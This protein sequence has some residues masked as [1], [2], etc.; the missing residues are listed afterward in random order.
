MKHIV[1]FLAGAALIA[2]GQAQAGDSVAVAVTGAV[3]PKC[4]ASAFVRQTADN[5]S[6]AIG[7]GYDV[8]NETTGQT[9]ASSRVNLASATP[10]RIADVTAR[11]N[12]GSATLTIATDN[13]FRLRN[14]AGGTGSEIP[15]ALN[16]QGQGGASGI[17][18]SYTAVLTG[19]G[20]GQAQVRP[21]FFVLP[22][23]INP[24]DLVPGTF[25]DTL[26]VTITPNS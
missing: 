21:L 9:F 17:A 16:L 18:A 12:T 11:C 7:I 1:P 13:D 3:A 8:A 6:T 15:F 26:R 10:Q 19:T 5:N 2:S 4:E 25:T 23:I 20:P 14:P 24:V 22:S